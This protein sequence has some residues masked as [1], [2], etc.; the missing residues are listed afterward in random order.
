MT[1]TTKTEKKTRTVRTPEQI[2]ADL[3]AEIARVKARAA[4]TQAK[5]APEGKPFMTAVKVVDKAIKA[6]RDAGN[7]EMLQALESA[8]ATLGEQL[9]R[10]GVRVPE[11]RKRHPKDAAA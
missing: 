8:R 5:A 1:T 2:V 3:E 9:T 6:A 11:T 4:A 10:M 7:N